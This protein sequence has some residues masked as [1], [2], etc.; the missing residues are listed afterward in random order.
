MDVD[1]VIAAYNEAPRV[2]AVVLPVRAARVARRVLVVDDGSTDATDAMARRAGAEVLRLSPNG[3]KGAA[4][5]VGL[6]ATSAPVVLFLDADL[7]NLRPEHVRR[8]LEPVLAGRAVM[9]VGLQDHG[10]VWRDVQ[11]DIPPISG[12]RAVRRE[13]A[14]RVPADFWRGFRIEAALNVV[15]RRTGPV[16]T[17]LLSGMHAVSK[18]AKTGRAGLLDAAKMVVEVAVAMR[19]AEQIPQPRA[20]LAP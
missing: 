5:R 7:V 4:M 15:A 6:A 20:A 12:Q 16:E 13:V 11:R 18:W 1:V 8:L 19:D 17:V 10:P 9:S 2:G 14:L 3:G